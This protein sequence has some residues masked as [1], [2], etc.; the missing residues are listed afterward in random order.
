MITPIIFLALGGFYIGMFALNST[1]N[2]LVRI[3]SQIPLFTPFIM[4]F[5]VAAVTVSST[6]IAIS[7]VVSV[8]FMAF[9]LWF[10]LLFY[11]SNVL[12]YSYKGMVNVFKRSFA[13]CI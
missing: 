6:E 10:S 1:N 7:I 4:P 3:T 9:V 5:R 12:L 11:L 8:L 2:S 13:L